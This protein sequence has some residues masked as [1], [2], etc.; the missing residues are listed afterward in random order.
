MAGCRASTAAEARY[1]TRLL[2]VARAG[3]EDRKIGRRAVPF[4]VVG[5]APVLA[6]GD[7][8][9]L[10]HQVVPLPVGPDREALML[11]A[12]AAAVAHPDA[13]E[14]D[15]VGLDP[16]ADAGQIVDLQRLE[17]LEHFDVTPSLGEVAGEFQA[18]LA[19]RREVFDDGQASPW[20]RGI[21]ARCRIASRLRLRRPGP[22]GRGWRSPCR[23]AKPA[24]VHRPN[25]G[26]T[27][28]PP[29]AARKTPRNTTGT[30]VTMRL[31]MAISL[32]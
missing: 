24:R 5:P 7:L 25:V 23:I 9:G 29:A 12:L 21:P 6:A 26:G 31:G 17:V 2:L 3:Q 4:A 27:A 19:F 14:T 11:V 16:Q 32:K 13:D 8:G 15:V 20:R 18:G 30:A 28:R 1:S 10:Q 22:G